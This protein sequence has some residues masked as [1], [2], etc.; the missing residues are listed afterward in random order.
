MSWQL[1]HVHI[2]FVL[3]E[4]SRADLEKH[5]SLLL[6]PHVQVH[7]PQIYILEIRISPNILNFPSVPEGSAVWLCTKAAFHRIVSG[8][9]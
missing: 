4:L 8:S 5:C 2:I 7:H 1:L 3:P 6:C 9:I